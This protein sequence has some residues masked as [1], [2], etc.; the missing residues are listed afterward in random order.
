VAR[1]RAADDFDTI[2]LRME[3]LRLERGRHW[4]GKTL[5]RR[6]T[7]LRLRTTTGKMSGGCPVQ[8]LFGSSSANP[9]ASAG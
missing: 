1:S 7:G 6:L 3:E 5:D 2:R 9:T 4:P 8:F